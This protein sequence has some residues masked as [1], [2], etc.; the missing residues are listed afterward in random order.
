MKVFIQIN[1]SVANNF[2]FAG[3]FQSFRVFLNLKKNLVE[4][5]AQA[6]KFNLLRISTILRKSFRLKLY[7][8]H[9]SH[10]FIDIAYAF[11]ISLKKTFS[12]NLNYVYKFI[13]LIMLKMIE[14]ASLKLEI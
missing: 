2:L 14:K 5:I 9:K 3:D 6:F 4:W 13:L 10:I 11:L 1:L 7:T 12:L 8:L